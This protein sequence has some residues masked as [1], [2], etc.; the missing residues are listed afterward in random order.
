M[1]DR[2]EWHQNHKFS[3]LHIH[4]R[5]RKINILILYVI[6]EWYQSNSSAHV[7]TDKLSVLNIFLDFSSKFIATNELG[8]GWNQRWSG[9]VFVW[10][11]S[12]L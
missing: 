10:Y 9:I 1:V 3:Q 2:P 12:G 8:L 7:P 4:Y 5:I 6:P 11:H